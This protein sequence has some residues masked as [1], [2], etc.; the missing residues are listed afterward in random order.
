MFFDKR[1]YTFSA[2][3]LWTPCQC[4]MLPYGYC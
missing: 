3:R 4:K 1:L 2:P